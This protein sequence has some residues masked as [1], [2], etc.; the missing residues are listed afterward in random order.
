QAAAD[1]AILRAI[2]TDGHRV[3]DECTAGRTIS[4]KMRR[5]VKERDRTCAVPGCDTTE[6][7]QTHHLHDVRRGGPTQLTNLARVCPYHHDQIT[8]KGA[9]LTGG[10][11]HWH[12]QPPPGK[13]S[14]FDLPPSGDPP[15]APR[16]EAAARPDLPP[17]PGPPPKPPPIRRTRRE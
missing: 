4:T 3:I 9:E 12:W 10:H 5:A 8:Y 15:S 16:P 2:L 14:I 1:D 6:G 17:S 11:P 7:L 13:E